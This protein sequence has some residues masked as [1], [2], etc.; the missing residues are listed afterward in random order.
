MVRYSN[1]GYIGYN[2]SGS[3]RGVISPGDLYLR[4]LPTPVT[5]EG[6]NKLEEAVPLLQAGTL[7]FSNSLRI[8]V[9]FETDPTEPEPL[10]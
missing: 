1:Q 2:A 7:V 6:I 4:S 8:E 5:P 9:A 10:G 3:H